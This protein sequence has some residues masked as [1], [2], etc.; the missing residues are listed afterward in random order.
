[1]VKARDSQTRG[2][3]FDT[4]S[5]LPSFDRPTSSLLCLD[6]G[7]N[8]PGNRPFY[9]QMFPLTSQKIARGLLDIA[10][11]NVCKVDSVKRDAFNMH[12]GQNG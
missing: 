6:P 4:R 11:A 7:V 1:M 2:P 12:T 3:W 9:K 8:I 5:M 10:K